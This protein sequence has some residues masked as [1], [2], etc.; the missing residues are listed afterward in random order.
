[1]SVASATASVAL[2]APLAYPV[3]MSK[4]RRRAAV[5]SSIRLIKLLSLVP[6][7]PRKLPARQLRDCLADAGFDVDL[8]TVQRDLQ[9]LSSSFPVTSDE[10]RPE[11]GWQYARGAAE[12]SAPALDERSALAWK[13]AEQYLEALLPADI[14]A[15][16]RPRFEAAH[17]VLAASQFARTRRWAERVVAK[18]RGF[19]LMAPKVVPGVPETIQTALLD[20]KRVKLS[21][22]RPHDGKVLDAE[23]SVLGLVVRG[24][25]TYL[26]TVFWDYDDVRLLVMHRIRAAEVLDK[27]A[28]EP[29]GFSFADYVQSGELEWPIGPVRQLRMQVT[30]DLATI[31]EETPIGPDQ[32]IDPP[33]RGWRQVTVTVQDT[34]ELRTWIDSLG[35]RRRAVRFGA[36]K[37][38]GG[39]AATI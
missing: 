10:A 39:P 4:V 17:Q 19:Q 37:A 15:Q 14:H 20:G 36:R 21:Y 5:D 32:A 16:L 9:R 30:P 7:G 6:R 33:K 22:R 2:D 18:P 31:L 25:V 3:P 38:S 34:M 1:M 35:E 29:K 13:L 28:R 8:R 27:P 11:A 24:Q 23:C 12:L 26:V